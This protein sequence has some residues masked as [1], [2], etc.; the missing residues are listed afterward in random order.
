MSLN[1]YIKNVA[2]EHKGM[3]SVVADCDEPTMG[4]EKGKEYWSSFCEALSFACMGV[5]LT[6]PT[7]KNLV[8]FA[9]RVRVYENVFGP[10]RSMWDGKKSV[11]MP[12]T[13]DELRKAIG[14]ETNVNNIPQAAFAKKIMLGVIRLVEREMAEKDRA[15]AAVNKING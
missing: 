8:E 5:D 12:F 2:P 10:F 11:P 7:Q 1:F 14:F 15:L 6:G 9:A 13:L 4:R 3:F